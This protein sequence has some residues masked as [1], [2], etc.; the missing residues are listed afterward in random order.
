MTC[1]AEREFSVNSFP[2][3]PECQRRS[4]IL[5]T[6]ENDLE[7]INTSLVYEKSFARG[8]G[9]GGRRTAYQQNRFGSGIENPA[10]AGGH[11]DSQICGGG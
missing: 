10:D 11:R 8:Y 4:A 5:A 1:L 9:S 2:F 7:R 6:K 3:S